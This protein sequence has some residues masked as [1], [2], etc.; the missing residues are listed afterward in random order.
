MS[1]GPQARDRPLQRGCA[2]RP[3]LAGLLVRPDGYVAWAA[4]A[5]TAEG[6][7][8]ADALTRWFGEPAGS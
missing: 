1:A 8:L 2:A 5:G 4:D 7:G 3:D 6:D